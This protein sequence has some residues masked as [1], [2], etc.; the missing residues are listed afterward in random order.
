[1][2]THTHTHPFAEESIYRF[3][4]VSETD[5][6]ELDLRHVSISQPP[7]SLKGNILPPLSSSTVFL[8]HPTIRREFRRDFVVLKEKEI[9]QLRVV[10]QSIEARERERTWLRGKVVLGMHR[11]G[12]RPTRGL[13][14]EGIALPHKCWRSVG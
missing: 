2:Y 3:P 9:L 13:R 1:M 14:K 5:W 7:K 12:G 11:T 10:L 4:N 6:A 8:S